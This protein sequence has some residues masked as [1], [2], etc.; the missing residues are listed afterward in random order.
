MEVMD[1]IQL[2]VQQIAALRVLPKKQRD[3]LKA[4]RVNAIVLLGNLVNGVAFLIAE[5]GG[6]RSELCR[7]NLSGFTW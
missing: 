6:F 3:R 5:L 2:T 7:I 4:D 1:D